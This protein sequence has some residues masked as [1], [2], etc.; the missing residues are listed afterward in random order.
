MIDLKE[1]QSV[2]HNVQQVMAGYSQDDTWSDYDREAHSELIKMQY[3]VE[4]ELQSVKPVG[5]SAEKV[6]EIPEDLFA[7]IKLQIAQI[8]FSHLSLSP[9]K[10]YI[11][12]NPSTHRIAEYVLSLLKQFQIE[13][14]NQFK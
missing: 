12:A 1:F 5:V 4:S 6:W 13:Y 8:Q 10:K 11:E 7:E 2:L 9:D 3:K 14:A